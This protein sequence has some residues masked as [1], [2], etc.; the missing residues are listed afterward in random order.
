MRGFRKR[1]KGALERPCW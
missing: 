1:E